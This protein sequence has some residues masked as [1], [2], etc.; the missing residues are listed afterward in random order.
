MSATIVWF[1]QD[2]RLRD[3]FALHAAILRGGPII[4]VYIW[5]PEEEGEWPPGA[6]S[7]WWLHQSLRALDESLRKRGSRLV[8]AH[9]ATADTLLQL[10]ASTRA[11]A[12][13]WNRR[14]EPD[15]LECSER[16]NEKL[17]A[18]GIEARIFH[19]SLL[20]EPEAL[21]NQ[22]GK[23]YRVYSAF[24]RRLLRDIHPPQ[25]VHVSAKIMAPRRWPR[26]VALQSLRLMPRVRWYTQMARAWKPGEAGA[27]AALRL[28][29]RDGLKD[30]ATGRERPGNRGT[31]RLSPHLH[32]GEIGPRQV[33]HAL[34]ARGRIIT[35]PERAHLARIRPSPAVSF[36]VH[37]HEAAARGIRALPVAAQCHARCARGSE[38]APEF[39]WSMQGC[40][41]C[42]RTG[43]MHN[44]VRMVAAS[45]L[46][47]NL[48]ITVAG[49]RALV[50]GHAG[51]CGSRQQHDEL[52]VGR[53]ERCGRGAL[54]PNIQSR[55][56]GQ[57]LRFRRPVRA[58]VDG[59][60]L[61]QADRGSARIARSRARGISRDA[62]V[63][64]VRS[65]RDRIR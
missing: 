44:R 3:N 39:R 13:Y 23:P 35:I 63:S 61:M 27:H 9:G 29:M 50:L 60:S 16:V 52:A 59:R 5:S 43:W 18:D 55:H 37:H 46:V 40:A 10:A 31:S 11:T 19:S 62:Q 24:R 32:F 14:Y 20:V 48:M 36:S 6:A 33:W 53:G 49:R 45:F 41:S 38:A 22:S 26:A 21:L 57:A 56:A 8:L 47:K 4:P 34:G 7:R 28:F 58:Q 30:Y 15:A 65:A 64:R 1:R 2:L 51:G 54:F 12:V 25:V 42:G 17:T